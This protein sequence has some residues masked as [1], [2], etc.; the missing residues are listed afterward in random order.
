M[1]DINWTTGN[2]SNLPQEIIKQHRFCVWKNEPSE[3]GTG[4]PKKIPYCLKYGRIPERNFPKGTFCSFIDLERFL[5]GDFLFKPNFSP[6]FYLKGSRLSVIDID[7]YHPSSDLIG[8]ITKF[9]EKGCYIEVSPSGNGLHIFYSGFLNWTNGRN[10]CFSS[11]KSDQ[12]KVTSCEVYTSKDI[13]FITLTGRMAFSQT[14]TT[15]IRSLPRAEDIEPELMRLKELF[16]LDP[17]SKDE[18]LNSMNRILPIS[19][20]KIPV[21]KEESIDFESPSEK[22][23]SVVA[24]IEKSTHYAK[25]LLFCEKLK[26]D[27]YETISETDMAFAGLIVAYMPQQWRLEDKANIIAEFF[28]RFRVQ[29]DKTQDRPGYVMSTAYE[30]LSN[31]DTYYRPNNKSFLPTLASKQNNTIDRNIILKICNVMQIFHL[32]KSYPNFQYLDNKKEKNS[33]LVKSPESLTP[34]DLKYFMEILF[35]YKNLSRNPDNISKDDFFEVNIKALLESLNLTRGG[36]AYQTFMKHLDK[37]SNVSLKYNKLIDANK[38]LYCL[39]GGSLLSYELYHYEDY[40]K[41][42]IYKWQKVKVKL[43]SAIIEMMNTAEYNYSLLNKLS[44]QRLPSDK[45]KFLY[46]YFCQNTWPGKEGKLFT[47]NDLMS[48]WPPSSVRTTLNSRKKELTKLLTDFSH[49]QNI[50]KDLIIQTIYENEELAKVKVVKR[51][52]KPV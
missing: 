32:G 13:R 42:N 23:K 48:L 27:E 26:L 7:N 4:K 10:K 39:Y 36:K 29:R 5:R 20:I 47:V 19:E 2:L 21:K 40:E 15:N 45:L 16:F 31:W 37:L 50:V 18:D 25:F 44:Y 46:V 11:L 33:I 41:N 34:T 1:Y 3:S 35:Q 30:A 24:K 49:H 51:M 52:L 6:G 14:K 8:L 43:A 22:L 28:K 12:A 17:K 38:N 9:Y